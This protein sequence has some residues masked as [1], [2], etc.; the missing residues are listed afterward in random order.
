MYM[1]EFEYKIITRSSVGVLTDEQ[2]YA[3]CQENS[4]LNFER[5]SSG[6]I[7]I[8]S[9]TGGK[10]SN[11][12]SKILALLHIWNEQSDL[13]IVFDSSGGFSLPNR[14]M[15]S[16]DAAWVTVERWNELTEEEKEGFPPL[17]PDFVIELKSKTDSLK[18]L[19]LK[20]QEWLENGCRL[21]WLIDIEEKQV[22]IYRP[23]QEA[24]VYSFSEGKLS[25]E[26]VLPGFSLNLQVL[27]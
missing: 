22:Y 4:H 12:N 10:T 3:F 16:P 27:L 17:C 24:E 5:T 19:K 15:R 23:Q 26:E 6:E 7:I 9:P 20:M 11:R 21:A 1:M 25:G 13:G 8:M 18:T 2:F 14:A